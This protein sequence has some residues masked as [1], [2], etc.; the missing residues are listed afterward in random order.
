MRISTIAANRREKPTVEMSSGQSMEG[1]ML[2]PR[3]T[4]MLLPW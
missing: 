1:S 2:L 4:L 3:V